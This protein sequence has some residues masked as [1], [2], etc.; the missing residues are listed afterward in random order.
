MLA[1]LQLSVKDDDD[2]DE[3]ATMQIG[4]SRTEL[5]VARSPKE[6]SLLW[7]FICVVAT[8][9]FFKDFSSLLSSLRRR[10]DSGEAIDT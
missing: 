4:C 10:I 7:T 2:D 1:R 9:R 5:S 3:L 6:T 8:N